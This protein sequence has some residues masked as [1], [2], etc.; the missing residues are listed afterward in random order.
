MGGSSFKNNIRWEN[1]H[2]IPLIPSTS[3]IERFFELSSLAGH[4]ELHDFCNLTLALISC[5]ISIDFC[6][7]LLPVPC[8]RTSILHFYYIKTACTYSNGMYDPI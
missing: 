5:Q 4:Q 3:G 2:Y 7:V 8:V 1:T 6:H